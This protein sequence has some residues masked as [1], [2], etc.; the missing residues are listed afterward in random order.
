MFKGVLPWYWG[1][2]LL[3]AAF[4]AAVLLVKPIGV[5]TQFV[6]ADA[7]V[8]DLFQPD[9]IVEDPAAKS[10]YASP[11]AYL[12]KSGGKYAA[13]AAHPLNYSF[14]FVLAMMAGA[15][16]SAMIK[17]DRPES[18]VQRQMPEV[19]RARFGDSP[20]KRYIWAF[21]AGSFVGRVIR[22][23]IVGWLTYA[24]GHQAL[25]IV[26]RRLLAVSV[27]CFFAAILYFYLKH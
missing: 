2:V 17:G 11:N 13:N 12:N 4:F 20:L 9:I 7:V 5:S 1:G 15:F 18:A 14:I 8:W 3:A 19:W 22:Y 27:I 23:G 10:G 16:L 6:I 24:Y 26:R 25:A 21:I